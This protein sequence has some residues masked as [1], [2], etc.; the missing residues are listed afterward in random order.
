MENKSNIIEAT[1]IIEAAAPCNGS[2]TET[3]SIVTQGIGDSTVI[4]SSMSEI[5]KIAKENSAEDRKR[6]MNFISERYFAELKGILTEMI[7]NHQIPCSA[8]KIEFCLYS[9]TNKSSYLELVI[10][11]IIRAPFS[12]ILKVNNTRFYKRSIALSELGK[13][14]KLVHNGSFPDEIR[15]IQDRSSD[16]DIGIV[17]ASRRDYGV[18]SLAHLI[19]KKFEIL[20]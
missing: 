19:P 9:M 3:T 2:E 8:S 10:E 20:F 14:L 17:F 4:I 7:Q 16:D 13:G 12:D 11:A 15:E 1:V 5:L 6:A 18:I